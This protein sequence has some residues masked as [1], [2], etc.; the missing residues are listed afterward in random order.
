MAQ[1][2]NIL[3]PADEYAGADYTVLRAYCM[4]LPI[5]RIADLYYTEDCP[6]VQEDLE[7]YL[8]RMRD[9]LIERQ[10]AGVRR[11]AHARAQDRPDIGQCVG[12]AGPG[13]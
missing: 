10:P 7:R 9:T 11:C 2:T 3:L 5:E 8:I 6:A 4:R 12:R 1:D 13:G